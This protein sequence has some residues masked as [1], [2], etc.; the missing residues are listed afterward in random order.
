MECS[1]IETRCE[2]Y[3]DLAVVHKCKEVESFLLVAGAIDRA[4]RRRVEERS[5]RTGDELEYLG[6]CSKVLEAFAKEKRSYVMSQFLASRRRFV[7]ELIPSE[8]EAITN[9]AALEEFETDWAEGPSRRLE[10]VPAKDALSAINQHLQ[11][12]YGVS[13]TAAGII[14][15]THVNEVPSEM[16]NLLGNLAE[17]A[18][19]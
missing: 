5:R 18:V 16:R 3:C 12:T 15:A 17:F 2:E 10:L 8:A 19:D 11:H 14:D 13:V 4:A 9:Q 7:R 6:E 1:A